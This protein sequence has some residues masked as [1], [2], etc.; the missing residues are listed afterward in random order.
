MSPIEE[1]FMRTNSDQQLS[2]VGY[3]ECEK[4]GSS[5]WMQCNPVLAG[6]SQL[7][8]IILATMVHENERHF[9]RWMMISC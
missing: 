7:S 4:I 5:V 2:G 8:T 3:G 6:E 1:C 9:S